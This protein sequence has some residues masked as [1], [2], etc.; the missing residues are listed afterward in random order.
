ME[1]GGVVNAGCIVLGGVVTGGSCDRRSNVQGSNILQQFIDGSLY[2]P[3]G[4]PTATNMARCL[5]SIQV[6][7]K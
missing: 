7:L 2:L 5:H 1:D 4:R 6:R 3:I